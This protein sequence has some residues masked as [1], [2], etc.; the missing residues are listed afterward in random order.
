MDSIRARAKSLMLCPLFLLI[1]ALERN[2]FLMHAVDDDLKLCGMSFSERKGAFSKLQMEFVPATCDGIG[3]FSEIHRRSFVN[4][5]AR[6]AAV[7]YAA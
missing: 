7:I 5:P 1:C 4:K 6:H 3:R 2:T